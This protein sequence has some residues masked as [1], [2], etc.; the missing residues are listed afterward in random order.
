M[1][2]YLIYILF[3]IVSQQGF[4]Q[5][6][7]TEKGKPVFLWSYQKEVALNMTNLV[8]RF[9]PLNL[10]DFS[11]QAIAMKFKAFG[12][13]AGFRMDLGAHVEGGGSLGLNLND[14]H[15]SLGY[16]RK[17]EVW[18]Q[19]WAL[20]TGWMLMVEQRN[21][22]GIVGVKKHVGIEYNI[23]PNVQVSTEV[24]LIAGNV[25][26]EFG[27]LFDPPGSVYLQVRF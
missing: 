7:T 17:Y 15:C 11:Q 19:K 8:Q 24:A 9:I 12:R 22:N 1:K 6:D 10:Q 18:K 23:N 21:D 3:I 5:V 14:F 2:K 26:G 20:T 25:F 27:V 16:E 13:K 4:S